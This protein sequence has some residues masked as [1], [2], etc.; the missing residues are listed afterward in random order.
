[1]STN[2]ANASPAAATTVSI[3]V[4]VPTSV[5]NF[6]VSGKCFSRLSNGAVSDYVSLFGYRFAALEGMNSVCNASTLYPL[7]ANWTIAKDSKEALI[8]IYIYNWKTYNMITANGVSYT[9]GRYGVSDAFGALHSTPNAFGT[10]VTGYTFP[11]CD[12]RILITQ[13]FSAPE[14]DHDI[15]GPP[16]I[17]NFITFNGYD[18]AAADNIPYSNNSLTCESYHVYLDSSSEWQLAPS[19]NASLLVIASASTFTFGAQCLVFSDGSSYSYSLS[20]C[21]SAFSLLSVPYANGNIYVA[22]NCSSKVM[23]RRP[24]SAVASYTTQTKITNPFFLNQNYASLDNADPLSTTI[25]GCQPNF[26]A[27]PTGYRLTTPTELQNFIATEGWGAWPSTFCFVTA[28]FSTNHS[29]ATCATLNE[30]VIGGVPYYYPSACAR[31]LLI[32]S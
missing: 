16:R 22:P 32:E 27:V 20:P 1:M 19:E 23:I 9:A 28:G 26:M 3:T 8:A 18:Y 6:C 13:N 29:N 7:P 24:S 4:A 31:T 30:L 10:G 12:S 11:S 17:S 14:P 5:N 21:T 15:A 25:S 2:T